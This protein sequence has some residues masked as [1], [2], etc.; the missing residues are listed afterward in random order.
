MLT[1][2]L[3]YVQKYPINQSKTT[4]LWSEWSEVLPYQNLQS[5]AILHKKFTVFTFNFFN[6]NSSFFQNI[7]HCNIP[8]DRGFPRKPNTLNSLNFQKVI[9]AQKISAINEIR[10]LV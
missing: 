1:N 3:S 5:I 4:V 2:L 9:I 8:L 10:T 6:F 7:V